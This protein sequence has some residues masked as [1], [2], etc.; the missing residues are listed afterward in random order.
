MATSKSEEDTQT[1]NGSYG[2]FFHGM[3]PNNNNNSNNDVDH[4]NNDDNANANADL[5]TDTPPRNLSKDHQTWRRI[6]R[7][8]APS[9]VVPP[10]SCLSSPSRKRPCISHIATH[11]IHNPK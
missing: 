4:S 6:V 10:P 3:P 2:N 8:F 11:S 9:Y 7:N 1:C 5:T